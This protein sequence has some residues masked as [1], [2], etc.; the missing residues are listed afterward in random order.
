MACNNKLSE[1][2]IQSC[3]DLPKKGLKGSKAVIVNYDDIDFSSTTTSGATVTALTLQS[4]KTG[5]SLEWYKDLGSTTSTFAPNTED[6]DGFTHSFLSRLSTS[7]AKNA[8]RSNELKNGRFV[9]AVETKYAGVDSLDAFKIYG[10]E[11]G[12]LLSELTV[13]TNENSGAIT[14]TL[15]SEEGTVEQY[16]YL[17]LNEGDYATNKASFDALFAEV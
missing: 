15:L 8:E 10:L 12:M 6:I 4:G 13:G 2:I 14:F 9:M 11:N 7:S 3:A 16:P 1:N 17:V 5:Y